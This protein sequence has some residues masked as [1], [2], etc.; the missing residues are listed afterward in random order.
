MRDFDKAIHWY[1][2]AAEQGDPV[3]QYHLGL[4]YDSGQGVIPDYVEAVRW[5]RRAAQQGYAIAQH[6][7]GYMYRVGNGVAQDYIRAHMWA[8]IARRNG[9][10]KAAVTIAVLEGRMSRDA[11]R[12]AT[13]LAHKCIESDYLD[14]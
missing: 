1:K 4:S 8:N 3:A 2:M 14:C 9:D 5:Y 7:I 6:A 12:H 11:I 10:N 13:S